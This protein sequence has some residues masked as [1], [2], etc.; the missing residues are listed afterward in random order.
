MET[1]LL[2]IAKYTVPSVISLAAALLMVRLF[3]KKEEDYKK[4]EITIKNKNTTLPLRLQSYERL[5]LLIERMEPNNLLTRILPSDI[6]AKDYQLM[7]ISTIKSEFDHKY[8]KLSDFYNDEI[9]T[10][11]KYCEGMFKY[12]LDMIQDN[13]LKNSMIGEK[14]KFVEPPVK[15]SSEIPMNTKGMYNRSVYFDEITIIK[16]NTPKTMK[17]DDEN[18]ISYEFPEGFKYST[19]HGDTP[20][21]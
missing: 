8:R 21:P 4:F 6:S 3:L 1:T 7:L 14:N 20:I 16:Y 11:N 18:T 13:S 5:T 2:E 17:I 19:A 10:L 9:S 12:I 15:D